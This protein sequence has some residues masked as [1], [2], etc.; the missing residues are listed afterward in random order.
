MQLDKII[1]LTNRATRLQFLAMERSLRKTGCT[2][3]IM[4]IPYDSELFELPSGSTWWIDEEFRDWH[5]E[6]CAHLMMRKYQC[7]LTSNY[8]FVDTDVVFT[9]NP[10]EAL[11]KLSGF[12]T[13]CG[14]W[15]DPSHTVTDQSLPILSSL[16]ANWKEKVF[17]AGQF[18]CDT[19]LYDLNSLA[20]IAA[21]Q[22]F[23]ETILDFKFHDQPG[24]NLLVALSKIQVTNLTLPPYNLNSS[25]A[26]DYPAE[27]S[28][29]WE[30]SGSS[31]YLIH[32]AGVSISG[33][34]SID[35]L[36]LRNL[37]ADE[38]LEFLKTPKGSSN[39]PSW[40][41]RLF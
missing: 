16:S 14:H 21:D 29:S 40:W 41:R 8:H 31:P 17:N 34:R 1:T 2:L 3:P 30:K 10:Q 15:R 36:F 22:E 24:M 9:K 38:R 12:I 6:T 11:S 5:Q 25:W 37:S 20:Q 4:A 27:F 32:W 28:A 35:Q 23:R 26:G 7:L 33:E 18:A 19:A 13:C 39:P